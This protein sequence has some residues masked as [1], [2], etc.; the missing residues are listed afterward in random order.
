[1]SPA[2]RGLQALEYIDSFVEAGVPAPDILRTITTNAARLLDIDK[3]RGS[4]RPGMAADLI[5][6]PGNPLTDINVLKQVSFVM[7]N[8]KIYRQE[9]R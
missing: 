7:P 1:M 8:G 3:V 5:A 9:N 4:L 2:S 6:V